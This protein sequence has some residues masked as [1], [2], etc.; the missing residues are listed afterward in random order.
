MTASNFEEP[1]SPIMSSSIPIKYNQ[2]ENRAK[3][4]KSIAVSKGFDKL[5]NELDLLIDKEN[6]LVQTIK[7][8]TNKE[9]ILVIDFEH[10]FPD[11]EF[12]KVV[13]ARLKQ[14]NAEI[15][16]SRNVR[17]KALEALIEVRYKVAKLKAKIEMESFKQG[18]IRFDFRVA[19]AARTKY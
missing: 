2:S 8:R 10:D 5:A 16:N 14:V 17:K 9:R 6:T 7:E 1:N 15:K 12:N 13:K 4:T 11:T 18:E 3:S 19:N